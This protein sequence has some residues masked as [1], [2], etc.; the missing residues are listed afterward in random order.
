M[1]GISC[2]DKW[3]QYNKPVLHAV[4]KVHA[5]IESSEEKKILSHLY[6]LFQR[7]D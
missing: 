5:D 7:A 3:L 6:C 4:R 1:V 2:K